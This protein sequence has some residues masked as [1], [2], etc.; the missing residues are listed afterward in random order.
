VSADLSPRPRWP[1]R[2][3]C[4]SRVRGNPLA[5]ALPMRSTPAQGSSAAARPRPVCP[6]ADEPPAARTKLRLVPMQAGPDA[7]NV[8]N[9]GAA[10]AKRV[11]CTRLLP[12]GRVGLRCRRQHQDRKRCCQHQTELEIP[13]PGGDHESPRALIP[14]LWVKDGGLARTRDAARNI[15]VKFRPGRI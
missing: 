6:G 8:R 4:L 9:L 2:L 13:G 14:E 5:V 3:N 1:Y 10:Q 7:I 15:H 11:A 12:F